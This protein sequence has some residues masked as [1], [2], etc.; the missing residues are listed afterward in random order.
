MANPTKS[1]PKTF[2]KKV[3]STGGRTA[4]TVLAK[5]PITAKEREAKSINRTPLS[6]PKI[7]FFN[8]NL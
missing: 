7:Y 3:T 8:D 6:M 1:T 5:P 4:L 2:L